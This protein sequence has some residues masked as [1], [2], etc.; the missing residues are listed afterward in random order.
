MRPKTLILFIVAIGCGLVA[1][2]GVSQYMEKAK[3]NSTAAVETA[4]IYVATTEI[5]P[6]ERLDA[7]NVRLEEWPKDR[8]PEG[9]ISDL[10]QLEEKFP[11]SRL[12]KGEPIL[13]AKLSD[14]MDGNLLQTIPEGFRVIALKVD[15]T[16]SGGGLI[17]PGD[18]VDLVVFLRKSAEIPETGTRTILRDVNVFAVSGETE[19]HMDKQGVARE[20]RTVSLLVT[21]RQAESVTL[22]KEVG[23]LSLTLR[24]PGDPVE[25]VGDGLNL[26]SLL[27]SD[28]EDANEN[29]NRDKQAPESG[30]V[31][32]LNNNATTIAMAP[33]PAPVVAPPPAPPKFVMTIRTP[34]GDR[35]FHFKE[36]DSDPEEIRDEETVAGTTSPVVASPV[37]NTQST[38]QTVTP[39]ADVQESFTDEVNDTDPAPEPNFSTDMEE[40]VG[41]EPGT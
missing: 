31:N 12:Y 11:R 4:K 13:M 8:I 20:V 37:S 5:S 26:K 39:N 6:G 19:R 22:A 23:I 40:G 25:E 18:R 35:K 41:L 33:A 34:N 16:T 28:S 10:K 3:G 36:L 14:T 21:P 32:W 38:G 29:K 1:S 30:L 27:G 24:R 7:K 17:R 15:E 9:A 2:I